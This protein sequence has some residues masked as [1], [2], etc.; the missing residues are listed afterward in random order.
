M[1]PAIQHNMETNFGC[2]WIYQYDR[3][4]VAGTR[5]NCALGGGA[6]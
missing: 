6:W 2:E 5:Q 4:I 3:A 1:E